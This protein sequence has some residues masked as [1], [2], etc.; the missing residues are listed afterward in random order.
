MASLK[1]HKANINK[2]TN[3]KIYGEVEMDDSNG[4]EFRNTA[5]IEANTQE[6]KGIK[7]IFSNP[8]VVGIGVTVIGGIAVALII[9]GFGIN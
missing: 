7:K 4:N 6:S 2:F 5:I 1:M 8:W 3:S 9:K